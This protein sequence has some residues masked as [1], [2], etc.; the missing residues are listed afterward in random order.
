MLNYPTA[1]YEIHI[2]YQQLAADLLVKNKLMEVTLTKKTWPHGIIFGVSVK[3]VRG[4]L[5]FSAVVWKFHTHTGWHLT[6]C[7]GACQPEEPNKLEDEAHDEKPR[8]TS[9]IWV[10]DEQT[11]QHDEHD[12]VK[13]IANVS[14]PVIH[15]HTLYSNNKHI[16]DN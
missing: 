16:F 6:S 9:E 10:G 8:V 5:L 11:P 2:T 1:M 4:Q 12:C 14:K 7:Q 3:T 15:S 13:H